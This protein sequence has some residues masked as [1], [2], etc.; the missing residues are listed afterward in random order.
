[1][2]ANYQSVSS[3]RR[4]CSASGQ[5]IVEC[6]LNGGEIAS[7]LLCEPTVCLAQA[8][9][10]N[11]EIEYSGKLVLAF[12][13]E[14]VE[15]KICRT[16][17]GAEFYHKAEHPQIAPAHTLSGELSVQGVKLRREGG[18]LIASCIV[19]AKFD[20]FG[21]QR[22]TYVA[23]GEG[24][25]VRKERAAVYN[26]YTAT[27]TVEEEDEFECD[28]A[29]DV[30]LHTECAAVTEVRTGMGEVNVLGELCMRFCLLKEDG[31]LC[32]YERMTPMKAQ[33]LLDTVGAD[34]VCRAKLRILSARVSAA[35]DEERKKS[36][37]VLS[38]QV[39]VEVCADEKTEIDCVVDAYA[40]DVEV[41]LKR[42]NIATRYALAAKTTTERV[43]GTPI[44]G[45]S[46]PEGGKLIAVVCPKTAVSLQKGD[47]G[48]ELQGVIEAKA[49]Y[50]RA[51]GGVE[52][53]DV[54][55][56]LLLPMLGAEQDGRAW[57]D[58]EV[59]CSVYGFGLRV[60]ADGETEAEGTV[61]VRITPYVDGETV[62]LSEV[63][64]GEKKPQ[65]T[66]AV[67]V[68]M[69]TCGEDAWTL[70]K[71]LSMTE[72]T[73]KNSNP[74]LIFPLKGEERILVYRQKQENLQK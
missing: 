47:D 29:K 8:T 62:Y 64:E 68:Y 54:A 21:E 50:Q 46:L 44:F 27:A 11:G 52:S 43:H 66:C 45:G 41:A 71:R 60:R 32:S 74:H 63:V 65:K 48:W 23:G 17:R 22:Y 19:E 33:V 9:C 13:Y 36:K 39:Q 10:G 16:E 35:T 73:L 42:E 34:S 56:P 69:P 18:Q 67:S 6:R 49:L 24:L 25:Q 70:A 3:I 4:L 1:M 38:Y 14:D 20:V 31:S 57:T 12:L 30:L 2:K 72:E 5:S 40:T 37:I 7:V 59:E 61:R 53:V 55:L 28:F 15:G 58:A 51:D 26:R